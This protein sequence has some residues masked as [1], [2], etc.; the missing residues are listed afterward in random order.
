MP[1]LMVLDHDSVFA[2]VSAAAAIDATRDAFLRHHSGE[3]QM[4]AKVYLQSPPHG[5]FRA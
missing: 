5:D 2:A 3:W 1:E 4:P